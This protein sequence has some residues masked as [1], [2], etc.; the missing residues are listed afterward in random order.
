MGAKPR[1]RD[2]WG[3]FLPERRIDVAAVRADYL[4]RTLSNEQIIEKH[5]ISLSALHRLVVA[6][7]WEP[8]APRRIDPN[9][10]AMRMLGLL[11]NQVLYLEDNMTKVGATEAA[12]LGK[13]AMTLDKLIEI[14]RAENRYPRRA[15]EEIEGLRSKIAE[16]LAELNAG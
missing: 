9:D 16:R 10:L 14:R 5:G 6:E 12:V 15:A 7:H 13:L 2:A 8:R 3:R 4:G 11:E 1:R